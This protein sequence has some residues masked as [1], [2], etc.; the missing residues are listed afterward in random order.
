MP[1]NPQIEAL[2]YAMSA[3]EMPAFPGVTPAQLR[4]V[5]DTP[6]SQGTGPAL[7]RVED[8]ELPLA[9]RRIPARLYVPEGAETPAPLTV[10]YH[11]GGWVIC[12]IETHDALCRQIASKS[13]APV[14][15]I[16]YRLAPEHPFPAGLDDCYDALVW[17]SGNGEALGID[18]SRLAVAGDSAGGNL[19][20]AVAIRARDEGGPRLRH[21]LL[22]YPVTDND[23]SHPS[24]AEHGAEGGFLTTAMMQW[25]WQHYTGTPGEAHIPLATVLRTQD[26][27]GLPPATV[28][29]AE[30][31]PL[32]DEG[33]AYAL[34]LADA[35]VPTEAEIAPGMIHGFA[36]MFEAA[37]DVIPYLDRACT[38]LR[39]ALA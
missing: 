8:L 31:D 18:P 23:M 33:M 15:S 36:S 38:R 14:L 35:G 22:F 2:L 16:G 4:A 1:L 6:L 25:F 24:Y 32:R 28:L 39:E 9:G 7:A 21:Q 11:G 10:F 37:P 34:R 30:Y 3:I 27:G 17:A 12:S 20:A 19:A 13:G 26:L 29:T 5:N